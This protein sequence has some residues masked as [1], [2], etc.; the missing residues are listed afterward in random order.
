MSDIQID[1]FRSRVDRI[2]RNMGKSRRNMR[3]DR[4]GAIHSRKDSVPKS[5]MFG[6]FKLVAKLYIIFAVTKA[7]LIYNSDQ[8]VYAEKIEKWSTG[9]GA[10]PIMSVVMAP[11]YFTV[12][13][14]GGI[15]KLAAF[16]KADAKK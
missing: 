5:A 10:A 16:I 2:E 3:R 8:A 6:T 13:I 12:P 14:H 1:E 9:V 4:F 11:D 15:D 7:A